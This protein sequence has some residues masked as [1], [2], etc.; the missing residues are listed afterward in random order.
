MNN[1]SPFKS[2]VIN[3]ALLLSGISITFN[4][5]LFFLDIHYQQAQASGIVGIVIMIGVILYAFIQYK[6]QN[7]G[8]MSLSEAL[9]VGLGISALA[10]LIGVVY[11]F[12]LSEFLDPDLMQKALDF[13]M[14]KM[15][16][17]NPEITQDQLE[18]IR[19]MQE[20]F[21]GPLIRSA[22][23]IIGSLFIGFIISLIGGLIVKKSRPE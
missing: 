2:I 4:L 10:A 14:D 16:I 3:H 21:S 11:S 17:E 20:K 6:K 1:Q 15:R 12:I 9:K 5:M 7:E 22:F 18:N 19:A 23:Q 8:F 13:Q